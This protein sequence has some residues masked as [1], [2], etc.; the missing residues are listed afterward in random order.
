[1][2]NAEKLGCVEHVVGH[3]AEEPVAPAPERGAARPR[4][5]PLTADDEGGIHQV[6]VQP[7]DPAL[8]QG[9]QDTWLIHEAVA[10]ADR[11]EALA[12]SADLEALLFRNMRH[13]L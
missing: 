1:G 13:V 10:D 11:V 9:A 8:R 2:R 5:H 6:E 12:E 4:P 7:S 3:Q